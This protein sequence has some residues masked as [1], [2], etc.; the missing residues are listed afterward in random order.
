[1]FTRIG[2]GTEPATT[3]SNRGLDVPEVPLT[4]WLC[5]CAI[6]G[7]IILILLVGLKAFTKSALPG[8]N[9]T[10][11]RTP[12]TFRSCSS[13]SCQRIRQLTNIHQN[14]SSNPCASLYFFTCAQ[15]DHPRGRHLR[16]RLEV[17]QVQSSLSSMPAKN[18][19][20]NPA[21][22]KIVA[23]YKTCVGVRTQSD[24][25]SLF[26]FL[27]HQ[28]LQPPSRNFSQLIFSMAARFGV[29]LL[30]Q[31]DSHHSTSPGAGGEDRTLQLNWNQNF[32]VWKTSG[33]RLLDPTVPYRDFVASVQ[34]LIGDGQTN[35]TTD[36]TTLNEIAATEELVWE[37][38]DTTYKGNGFENL[39]F[40][41]F[42]KL[43]VHVNP[44]TLS[45]DLFSSEI[46]Y[47]PEDSFLLKGA[48]LLPCL[49][50]ILITI[51]EDK[52][53]A[54]LSWE[55][56]RQM[57]P[58]FLPVPSGM[59]LNDICVYSVQMLLGKSAALLPCILNHVTNAVLDD[60][61]AIFASI[62]LASQAAILKAEFEITNGH[63]LSA[64]VSRLKGMHLRIAYPDNIESLPR[65]NRH[66]DAISD[67]NS[68]FLDNYISVLETSWKLGTQNFDGALMV[69]INGL[70]VTYD[71]Q[72]NTLVLPAEYLLPPL[73]AVDSISA[74]NYGTIGAALSTGLWWPHV[75]FSGQDVDNSTLRSLAEYHAKSFQCIR[76]GIVHVE[77]VF[78]ML[79][80]EVVTEAFGWTL[81][82]SPAEESVED[83]Q[84]LYVTS[85]LAS[86]GS[87]LN[88]CQLAS[89]G[90]PKFRSVFQCAA[91]VDHME[92]C[93]IV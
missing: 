88:F 38:I 72:H 93:H 76:G 3:P 50:T 26:R 53:A 75:P 90:L 55:A 36:A 46:P 42:K 83:W 6:A 28:G 85:C 20:D 56:A 33:K 69:G 21:L 58:F 9:E 91:Q 39:T 37:I 29:G 45:Q 82:K 60:V 24:K 49:D 5:A 44:D 74:A 27:Q 12:D 14:T 92:P 15:H 31:F 48:N 11:S 4:K 65:L 80:M 41:A 32:W 64:L 17:Q 35:S 18:Q 81:K 43:L 52:L 40:A 47:F 63:Q 84:L 1:M 16:A 10:T 79:A 25:E 59:P 23:F 66:L 71:L 89:A 34:Q 8:T 78:S 22:A 30:I 51:Q 70:R 19:A 57:A 86:C 87:G 62:R 67:M 73:Y 13:G 7:L 77:D 61:Q 68:G 54:Y 2:S